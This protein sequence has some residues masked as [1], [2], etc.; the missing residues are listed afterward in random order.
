M[1]KKLWIAALFLAAA[2]PG[3]AAM[4]AQAQAIAFPGAVGP[5]AATPGG[6]GGKI[7]R[8]T[9]LAPDGPGSLKAAIETPGPRIV[10]FEVGGVIDLGRSTLTIDQPYLTIAGQTAPGPGITIIRGGIDV[11][12]HD[13]VL[14]HLRIY[15]GV[16]GQP[17]RSGWEADAFS[18]VAAHDVVVDH[19]TF[20]WAL[21]ENMSASGPRFKGATVAEWRDGTSRN[22]T[23]SNN[24]AAEALADA[25]HPKG[26]HS[27]GSLIHDN[28]TGIVFYRNV[29][30][31][32]VER[33]PLI[34]GGAQALMI[35]N[36]IYDPGHRAVHY[37]LM[38]LEW[39]G[40]DY[41]TGEITAIG[42]VMRG[43]NH[44]DEGLPFLM[45]GGD[46]DLRFYGRDN[47]AVDRHGNALPEFGRYGETRAQL[48]RSEAP[49]A[50]TDGY[51]ILPVRDVETSVLATAGAR[52]WARDAEEIR[53]LFFVA[54]GRGDIIDDE[55]QVSAYPK[56]TE[57]VRAPFVEKDWDLATME[58]RSGTYP[59]QTAPMP[60]EHLSACDLDSRGGVK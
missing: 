24:L 16:D 12:A 21:D 13:V 28:T 60:Q 43:G 35:N 26:E 53:I 36:L 54:E 47:I 42:N 49:L 7:L 52:P 9:T 11:K 14:R 23:F 2:V 40:H 48:I 44:T 39:V 55:K 50:P 57:P 18:T 45:L 17:K 3:G 46:G 4:A 19:C 1:S 15:T 37:N 27:K 30:A 6:R 8:V 31:H 5:A 25:S 10:V 38:N 56:V 41:V 51:K 58:P 34:K 32:N 59:G 29:W 22:V 20:L 33:N